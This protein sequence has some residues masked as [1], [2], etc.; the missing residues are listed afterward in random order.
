MLSWCWT[1]SSLCWLRPA[2]DFTPIG[3][4]IWGELSTTALDHRPLYAEKLVA[5]DRRR[6][7]R[8]AKKTAMVRKK[9]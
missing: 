5:P 3:R 6:H 2:R 1:D 4:N 7:R 9:L 8:F